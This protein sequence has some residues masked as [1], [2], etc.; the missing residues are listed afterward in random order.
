MG[1]RN[2]WLRNPLNESAEQAKAAKSLR[3]SLLATARAWRLKET[4]MDFFNYRYAA[5]A[6]KF[7]DRWYAWAS[8]SRLDPIKKAAKT[9]KSRLANLLTYCRLPITNAASESLNS[10]I[11]WI[12]TVHGLG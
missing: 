7:F 8:R 1:T 11:Q 2:V 9:L 6:R 4:F 3:K 10:K 12:V 5:N